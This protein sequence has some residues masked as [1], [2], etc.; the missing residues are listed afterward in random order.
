MKEFE[1]VKDELYAVEKAGFRLDAEN[2]VRHFDFSQWH[3]SEEKTGTERHEENALDSFYD[4][5]GAKLCKDENGDLY[6]VEY[7]YSAALGCSTPLIWQRVV[8]A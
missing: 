1:I 8:K 7:I 3:L 4:L 5:D 2:D 6:A